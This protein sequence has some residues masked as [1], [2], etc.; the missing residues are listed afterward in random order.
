MPVAVER[1]QTKSPLYIALEHRSL[2]A[3]HQDVV[4]HT[5][6][7]PCDSQALHIGVVVLSDACETG[8]LIHI[9][10]SLS[11]GI[12]LLSGYKAMIFLLDCSEANIF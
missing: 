8:R 10:Q 1:L 11:I 9:P 5:A 4:H 3:F 2:D 6:L 7:H 12:F